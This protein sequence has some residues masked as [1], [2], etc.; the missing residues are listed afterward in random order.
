MCE[1]KQFWVRA[2]G[3]DFPCPTAKLHVFEPS[4]AV[5]DHSVKWFVLDEPVNPV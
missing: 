5:F 2:R 1:T 4:S 3:I